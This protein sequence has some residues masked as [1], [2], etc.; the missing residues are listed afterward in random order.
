[1]KKLTKRQHEKMLNEEYESIQAIEE[2]EAAHRAAEE[3]PCV[4]NGT[5]FV[6]VGNVPVR[7]I[8][9]DAYDDNPIFV[10]TKR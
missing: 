10:R 3:A 8:F 1:M 4:V 7:G 6:K 5:A 2:Q 9:Q